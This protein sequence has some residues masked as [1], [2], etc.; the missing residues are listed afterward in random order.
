MSKKGSPTNYE[1]EFFIGYKAIPGNLKRIYTPIVVMLLAATGF[2]G[3]S[4]ASHQLPSGQGMWNNTVRVTLEGILSVD[5]YPILHRSIKGHTTT[6][7]SV[8][9]VMTGK[10]AANDVS[11]EFSGRHVEVIG[12]PISRGGWHM[13]EIESQTD[14]KLIDQPATDLPDEQVLAV[15]AL[16]NVSLRGEIVDSKCFLGVMKP[17]GGPVHK[18]CA[19]MCMLGGIPPMLVVRDKQDR[20]FGYLLTNSDRSSAA[21]L[22]AGLAAEAVEIRG[23]LQQQGDMLYIRIADDGLDSL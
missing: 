10:H 23:E 12:S 13:L 14:I 3:Y 19:E 2:I 15:K 6:T 8:M 22:L 7:Q 11:R 21:Q 9:L 16:G 20:K 17:G 1:D 4:V 5:P 18:A